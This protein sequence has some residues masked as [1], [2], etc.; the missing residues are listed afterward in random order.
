MNRKKLLRTLHRQ[1]APFIMLPLV[2]TILTGVIYRVGKAWF[3][4]TRDQVHWLMVIH[5]GEYLGKFLEPFYVL[6]NG[7]GALFMLA[8][9]ISIWVSTWKPATKR[10]TPPVGD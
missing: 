10:Q 2:I 7:L 1:L 4:L 3:G 9:G 8:T 6:L 5:E